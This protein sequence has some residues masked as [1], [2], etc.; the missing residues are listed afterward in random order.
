[1]MTVDTFLM[2][3]PREARSV[4]RRWVEAPDRKDSTAL[5]RW[6]RAC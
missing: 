2:S 3:R 1:M 5:I 4:A 6:E